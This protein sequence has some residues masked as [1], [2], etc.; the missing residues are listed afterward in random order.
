MN[1]PFVRRI[2][3]L[4][5]FILLIICVVNSCEVIYRLI[6]PE[7]PSTR[8]SQNNLKDI[9]FPLSFRI[10]LYELKNA[11]VNERYQRLGYK[12]E[13]MFFLGRS[14]FNK[15]LYGWNGHT[16]NGGI[17]GSTEGWRTIKSR[18]WG[19]EGERERE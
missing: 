9:E 14:K 16:E 8:V 11:N 4:V 1:R 15:S 3:H 18:D 17:L 12:S 19:Y 7:L 2:I 6:H 10:C 5:N 13:V